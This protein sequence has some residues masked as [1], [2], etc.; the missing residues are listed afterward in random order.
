MDLVY[1]QADDDLLRRFERII[2]VVS[3]KLD[4]F[5][6]EDLGAENDA[7]LFAVHRGKYVLAPSLTRL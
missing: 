1:V 7:I 6:E 2:C 5:L 4:S 3:E